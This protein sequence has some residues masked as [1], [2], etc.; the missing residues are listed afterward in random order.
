MYNFQ[1]FGWV[2]LRRQNLW[3]PYSGSTAHTALLKDTLNQFKIKTPGRCRGKSLFSVR[4]IG[5]VIKEQPHSAILAR[6]SIFHFQSKPLD[7]L[8][9]TE[10]LIR[11]QWQK[12]S[13]HDKKKWKDPT[14]STFQSAYSTYQTR[15]GKNSCIISATLLTSSFRSEHFF[16]DFFQLRGKTI[17]VVVPN[18]IQPECASR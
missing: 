7:R 8:L 15:L 3:I 17:A 4:K 10:L 14:W 18:Q 11:S 2:N 16:H 9:Q 12:I 5:F 13:I 6:K 1:R